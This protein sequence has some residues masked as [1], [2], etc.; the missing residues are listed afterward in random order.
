[1]SL[2]R[3]DKYSTYIRLIIIDISIAISLHQEGELLL[4]PLIAGV[5][6]LVLS[7]AEHAPQ[8]FN[9]VEH[10]F[11][12]HWVPDMGETMGKH[13]LLSVLQVHEVVIQFGLRRVLSNAAHLFN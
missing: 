5:N 7:V 4:H 10:Q 8:S 13:P 12:S 11:V 2:P 1:M 9:R 3:V 6:L